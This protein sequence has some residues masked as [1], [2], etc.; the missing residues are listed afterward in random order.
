[1]R[2]VS[3]LA[4]RMVSALLPQK[5]AAAGCAP[6]TYTQ[7]CG[8]CI[9]VHAEHAYLQLQKQC[10]VTKACVTICGSC[11]TVNCGG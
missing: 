5:S 1:M 10:N 2:L 9:Y 7:S 4:D 6:S 3:S 8:S 11:Q